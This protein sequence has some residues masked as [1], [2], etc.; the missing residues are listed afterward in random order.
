MTIWQDNYGGRLARS[1]GVTCSLVFGVIRNG[2]GGKGPASWSV[3]GGR[4]FE[5]TIQNKYPARLLKIL[6]LLG[7]KI[8][9]GETHTRI[10]K[11]RFG[12]A[13]ELACFKLI[14]NFAINARRIL[15]TY[16]TIHLNGKLWKCGTDAKY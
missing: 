1:E 13:K 4:R 10:I 3:L 7:L 2:E 9:I 12:S 5:F 11:G 8:R 15:T 14:I 16:K 6:P